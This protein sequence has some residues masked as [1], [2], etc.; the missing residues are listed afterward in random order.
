M[1]GVFTPVLVPVTVSGTIT[2]HDCTLQN[3]T[4]SVKDEYGRVKPSGPISLGPGGTYSFAILLQAS[5]RGSD[6][7]GRH[8][9]IT[10]RAKD[11]S[12]NVGSK[13]VVVTVPHRKTK[14]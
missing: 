10:V 14:V 3:A 8:Y 6:L 9:M 12:G 5:R 4:Y 7:D 2:D 11:K 1:K 13:S